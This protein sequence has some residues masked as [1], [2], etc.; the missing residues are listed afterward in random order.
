MK[1]KSLDIYHFFIIGPWADSP[2]IIRLC[3]TQVKICRIIW[4]ERKLGPNYNGFSTWVA[5]N[6]NG[7]QKTELGS[8]PFLKINEGLL[9][10]GREGGGDKRFVS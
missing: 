7:T 3:F 1:I 2:R 5:F 6:T 4:T 9:H 8:S 10:L